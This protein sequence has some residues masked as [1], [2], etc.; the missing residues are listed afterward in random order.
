MAEAGMEIGSHGLTHRYLITMSRA[1]AIREIC[2]SKKRLEQAIG[3]KVTSFAPV[4]GHFHKW[5]VDVAC[6]AGFKAFASMIPGRTYNNSQNML[7][8]RRNHIQAHH[9]IN[10]VSSLLRGH[11]K[12]LFFN[13]V[14]Y[15][16]LSISKSM[17]GMRNYDWLKGEIL[18][19][20]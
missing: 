3:V 10:Y 12:N 2:E 5:M 6:E 7:L 14:Q 20:F 19:I 11:K 15:I 9:D 1:D 4:G 16:L 18:K 17:L 8:M 13:R